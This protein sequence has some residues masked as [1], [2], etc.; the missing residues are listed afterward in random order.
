MRRGSGATRQVRRSITTVGTDN[1]KILYSPGFILNTT[2]VIIN[3]FVYNSLVPASPLYHSLLNLWYIQF[4][5][6]DQ[7]LVEYRVKCKE[8]DLTFFNVT[9][10]DLEGPDTCRDPM[11]NPKLIYII[12]Y[13]ATSSLIADAKTIS[14]SIVAWLEQQNSVETLPPIIPCF[15]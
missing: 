9:T 6:D 2:Y 7:L 13:I 5:Y 12:L 11:G 1:F 10:L 4:R 8:G 15:H 14:S 3:Y